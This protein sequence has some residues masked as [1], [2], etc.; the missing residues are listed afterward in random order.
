MLLLLLVVFIVMIS[1]S[2]LA[3]LG[4]KKPT[5]CFSQTRCQCAYFL[6]LHDGHGSFNIELYPCMP[7]SVTVSDPEV[8]GHR[9]VKEMKLSDTYIFDL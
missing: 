3:V 1:V 7:V 2:R 6:T 4:R 5:L 8:Q 9:C